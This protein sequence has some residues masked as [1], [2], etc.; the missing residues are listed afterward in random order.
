MGV[1]T[2]RARD[3]GNGMADKELGGSPTDA[4]AGER[5]WGTGLSY[6]AR[7]AIEARTRTTAQ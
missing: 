6:V 1:C 4:V 5:R 3:W 2:P 7:V